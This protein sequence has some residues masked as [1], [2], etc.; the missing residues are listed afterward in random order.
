LPIPNEH[1]WAKRS[2]AALQQAAID[3]AAVIELDR[4]AEF[5][6]CKFLDQ[7]RALCFLSA[8]DVV[9]PGTVHGIHRLSG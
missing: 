1:Q 9:Q 8:R 7:R 2:A 4:T 5:F 6:A 3:S